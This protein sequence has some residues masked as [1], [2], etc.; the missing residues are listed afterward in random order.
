MKGK[1]AMGYQTLAVRAKQYGVSIST[2]RRWQ[3]AGRPINNEKALAVDLA[4]GKG[5]TKR[6]IE[7]ANQ[8]LAGVKPQTAEDEARME[9]ALA[10]TSID[11]VADLERE[12]ARFKRA[13]DQ[14]EAEGDLGRA[15]A[16]LEARM[17]VYKTVVG[18][19]KELRRLGEDQAKNITRN[20]FERM[21]AAMGLH[22]SS[23]IIAL[24]DRLGELLLDKSRVEQVAE[25]L[26][27]A[28]VKGLFLQPFI[29]AM[30]FA[31]DSGLPAWVVDA[32]RQAFGDAVGN[33][34]EIFNE[35]TGVNINTR[36]GQ[37][38]GNA[39]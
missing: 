36:M 23:A 11:M 34:D 15:D 35:A 25:V 1:K 28:M 12:A 13:Q 2:V 31:S 17:K 4:K 7:R 37:Q 24:S 19:R 39:G 30:D 26:Q 29:A 16:M 38:N 9:A 10:K 20:E 18:I 14:A 6:L 21:V 32:Y 8:I 27:P 22:T 5:I 33:G 3:M